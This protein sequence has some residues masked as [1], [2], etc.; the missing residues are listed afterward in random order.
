MLGGEDRAACAAGVDVDFIRFL[1]Y[2]I[3]GLIAAGVC[4]V[5]NH[6]FEIQSSDLK[7]QYEFVRCR[8]G[9][10]CATLKLALL[11]W[12]CVRV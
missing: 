5:A 4:V 9:N 1:T 7:G 10:L 12:C 2:V 6:I 3:A 11:R 8:G